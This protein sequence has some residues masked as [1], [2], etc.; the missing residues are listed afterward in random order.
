MVCFRNGYEAIVA[1]PFLT[2]NLLSLDHTNQA[3]FH[4][5]KIATK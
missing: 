1:D 3:R 4:D 2:V 5:L